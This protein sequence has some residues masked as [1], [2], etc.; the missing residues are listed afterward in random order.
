MLFYVLFLSNVLFYIMFLSNVL[1]YVLSVYKSE[2][3]YCH[4]VSTQLQLNIS[5]CSALC[6]G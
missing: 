2:F 6:E 1:L 4:N 3:Y 5:Y